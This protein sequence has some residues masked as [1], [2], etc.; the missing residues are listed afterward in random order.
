MSAGLLGRQERPLEMDAK[1]ARAFRKTLRRLQCGAHFLCR[2]ANQRWHQPRRAVAPVGGNDAGYDCRRRLIIE[3]HV[4]PSIDLDINET[5][6]QPAAG[7]HV[8]P[9]PISPQLLARTP[10]AY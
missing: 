9:E 6:S 7:W 8:V 3:K 4:V 1:H 5:R 2:V 10:P